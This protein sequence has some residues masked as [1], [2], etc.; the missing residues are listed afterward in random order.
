MKNVQEE[1]EIATFAGGCF[2][3]M[4][5]PFDVEAGVS[6]VRVG[7]AGGTKEDAKY[8]K[9]A[10]KKTDHR[11]AL[12]IEYD[13]NVISYRKLLEIFFRQIDPTDPEG[14]FA[15]KGYQYTTAIY[16]HSPEQKKEG[17]KYREELNQSG[18]FQLPIATAI[19]PFTTF[20]DAEDEHQSYYKKNPLRYRL[21]KQGSG[22]AGYIKKNW[23]D[24]KAVDNNA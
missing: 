9:V 17:E 1:K 10:S 21:Y 7:Y 23:G 8:M 24:S 3:C 15:D 6:S 11:E 5:A 18:K 12:Q 19:E 22:R 2:W 4:Q 14:Q 13:P 16:Y 20:F